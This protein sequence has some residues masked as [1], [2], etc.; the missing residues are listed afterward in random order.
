MI[1]DNVG[2]G[3]YDQ[4][5]RR[6]RA[7][8]GAAFPTDDD[9]DVSHLVST[10]VEDGQWSYTLTND[11]MIVIGQ[12]AGRT[13]VATQVEVAGNEF[14][15]ASAGSRCTP[16]PGWAPTECR[17]VAADC[18]P[19][20]PD[21]VEGGTVITSDAGTLTGS[22]DVVD[23]SNSSRRRPVPVWLRHDHGRRRYHGAV[24]VHGPGW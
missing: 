20:H 7:S 13:V 2:R 21:T 18:E 23:L 9:P 6:G 14:S 10:M 19:G 5:Y 12:G 3:P 11:D 22:D 1:Q 24:G 8:G 4:W 16:R 17:R 15:T